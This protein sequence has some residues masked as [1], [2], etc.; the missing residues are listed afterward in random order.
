[1]PW[2]SRPR[3]RGLVAHLPW[4]AQHAVTEGRFARWTKETWQEPLRLKEPRERGLH[5]QAGAPL[6]FSDA[7]LHESQVVDH[8]LSRDNTGTGVWADPAY[9]SEEMEAKLRARKLKSHIHH[10]GRRGKPLTD[11][12]KCSSRTKSSVRARVGHI[13]GAQVND[14]RGTLVRTIGSMRAKAKIAMRNLVFNMP[15]RSASSPEPVP[16]VTP[17]LG[18]QPA[19]HETLRGTGGAPKTQ[20][21]HERRLAASRRPQA[22]EPAS[23]DRGRSEFDVPKCGTMILSQFPLDRFHVLTYLATTRGGVAQL[24]RAAES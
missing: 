2:N 24:V 4:N 13:F 8:L 18:N 10:K 15:P 9:R 21:A 12:A 7:A 20:I 19:R 22:A 17:R 5:T 23:R 14:M 3:S 16:D 6:P 11:L 1:M